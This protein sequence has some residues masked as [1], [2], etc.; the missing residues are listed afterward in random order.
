[1]SSPEKY[2]QRKLFLDDLKLLVKSEHEEIFR[3]LKRDNIS[4]T[5]NSNGIFFD[6]LQISD[7]TFEKV[8]NYMNLCK[9][10]RND[11]VNRNKN[12]DILRSA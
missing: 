11:E 7:E 6:L 9:S 8:Q 2:E 5:E 1:M 10:Q 3:I 12:L 4:Y